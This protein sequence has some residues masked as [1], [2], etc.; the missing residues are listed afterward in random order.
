MQAFF[1]FPSAGI[2]LDY[3]PTEMSAS[4]LIPK[5][6]RLWH[7]LYGLVILSSSANLILPVFVVKHMN[8][9]LCYQSSSVPIPADPIS[10]CLWAHSH[11]V[12]LTDLWNSPASCFSPV[13]YF[14]HSD[15]VQSAAGLSGSVCEHLVHGHKLPSLSKQ[16]YLITWTFLKIKKSS[17]YLSNQHQ[18]DEQWLYLK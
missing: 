6:P 3:Y 8:G 9:F 4:L 18:T 2:A 13:F 10:N 16:L 5:S 17:F 15:A 7:L 14:T 1:P 12:I 11:L